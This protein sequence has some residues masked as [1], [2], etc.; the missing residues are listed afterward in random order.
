MF[1]ADMP[2]S[3]D[4]FLKQLSSALCGY[5]KIITAEFQVTSVETSAISSGMSQLNLRV[6]YEIVATGQ[7]FFREQL[8]GSWD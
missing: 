4:A 8:V 5:Q 6:R 3:R 2:L 1:S 7:D